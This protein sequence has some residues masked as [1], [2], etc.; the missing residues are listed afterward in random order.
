MA[1]AVELPRIAVKIPVEFWVWVLQ[2]KKHRGCK[3]N[4]WKGI[5][6]HH[7]YHGDIVNIMG[8]YIHIYIYILYY[9]YNIIYIYIIKYSVYT[10]H[11][12]PTKFQQYDWFGYG[13]NIG[14]NPK[15]PVSLGLNLWTACWMLRCFVW[16]NE[17]VL[18]THF[19]CQDVSWT[20]DV[21][22]MSPTC[23]WFHP[24]V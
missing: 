2:P 22:G 4:P 20:P 8:Y 7:G 24:Q 14:Q 23:H 11:R 5:S 13:S 18:A 19:L 3:T 6:R 16:L 12:Y 10:R 15:S 21:N 17:F 9:I 1:V